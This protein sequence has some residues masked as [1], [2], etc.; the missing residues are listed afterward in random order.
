[1]SRQGVPDHRQFRRP[2]IQKAAVE[3][4]HLAVVPGQ[5]GQAG[6]E[7]FLGVFGGVP[8]VAQQAGIG[9]AVVRGQLGHQA[10]HVRRLR[11]DDRLDQFLG[12]YRAVTLVTTPAQ[13]HEEEQNG[14][15]PHRMIPA[16]LPHHHPLRRGPVPPPAEQ[17]DVGPLPP[18]GQVA[19]LRLGIP[20]R[21]P[22]R[23]PQFGPPPPRLLLL[24][25][26]PVPQGMDEIVVQQ[27]E[28]S[29]A[30]RPKRRPAFPIYPFGVG[31][32]DEAQFPVEEADQGVEVPRPCGVSRCGQQLLVGPHVALDVGADF[33]QQGLQH[34]LGGSL[35]QA[36]LRRGGRGDEGFFEEGDAHPLHAADFFQGGRSPRL[37]LHHFRKEGQPHGDD[38]TVLG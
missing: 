32:R 20:G 3:V 12:L 17:A 19:V 22:L 2:G 29:A 16:C 23:Q 36:V 7:M 5:Q 18:G 24:A 26:Q 30:R 25:A 8:G 21:R 1:M 37:A 34:G 15:A 38:L 9:P 33:R 4:V 14:Q 35:V 27:H 28:V 6:V 10:R 31:R 13:Q 11:R